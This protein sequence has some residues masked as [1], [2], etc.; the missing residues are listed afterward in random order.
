LEYILYATVAAL[1]D[2]DNVSFLGVSR[3]LSDAR[4]R[5]WVVRQVKDPAVR[6]FWTEEFAG[7]ETR[8]AHEAVAPVQNKV[9]QLLMAAPVR[10]ILG[11]VGN[12]VDARF[13]MDSER[14]F[15]A[16][17]SKGALGESKAHLLGALLV[18]QFQLAAMSRQDI[19]EEERK[20]FHLY[21]DE[22]QSFATDSFLGVL[23]EAR[24]F[25][26]SL[27]LS[28][29]YAAQL[30]PELQAGVFGNVGSL[31]SFRVGSTDGEI[32]AQEFGNGYSPSEFTGMANHEVCAKLLVD[33]EHRVPFAGRSLPP[34][35]TRHGKADRIITRSRER[36]AQSG[37]VVED[38]IRRWMR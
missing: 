28:H 32:L 25:R 16:N 12:R 33:G 22:F 6:F 3:M 8:F 9:G 31:V 29:Q 19:P 15:I 20:D 35:G 23:S 13:I 10:N 2:C 27:T 36:F 24:K 38:K 14:I 18:T 7:Y 26:L 34:S 37:A 11:Q 17:L 4:Y 30:S 1:M 21:V 5:A